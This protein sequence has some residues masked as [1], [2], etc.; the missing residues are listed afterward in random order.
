MR[1]A[2]CAALVTFGLA[3]PASAQQSET[4]AATVGTIRAE[5]RPVEKTLEFVG[6][7]EAVERGGRD[8]L[9]RA[10]A[11]AMTSAR[12]GQIRCC[13]PVQN[14]EGSSS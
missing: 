14:L 6:R 2:I 5:R 13:P 1:F 10:L 4:P 9:R 11:A 12:T 7:I 8:L 3:L